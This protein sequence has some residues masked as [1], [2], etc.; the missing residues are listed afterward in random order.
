MRLD[1]FT[2]K[3]QKL[4][5]NAQTMASQ[6]NNQQIEPEHLLNAILGDQDGMGISMLRKHGVNPDD[7]AREIVSVIDQFPRISGSGQ[8]YISE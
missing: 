1:K 4:I 3:S 2:I 6:N 5:Q 8:V 7:V